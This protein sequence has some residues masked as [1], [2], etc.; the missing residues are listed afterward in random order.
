M[1]NKHNISVFAFWSVELSSNYAVM[2]VIITFP[3]KE[4][5][6]LKINKVT[7]LMVQPKDGL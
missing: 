7:L 6:F 3:Q 5:H 4:K 2:H 1:L